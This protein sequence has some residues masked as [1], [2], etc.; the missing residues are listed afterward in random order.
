MNHELMTWAKVK[1]QMLNR[2]SPPGA[3]TSATF[4][5]EVQDL[6]C[7]RRTVLWVGWGSWPESHHCI[8]AMAATRPVVLA[9]WCYNQ[10]LGLWV[11][12]W[13]PGDPFG[14]MSKMQSC[15]EVEN[16]IIQVKNH[17]EVLF[18]CLAQ[19]ST[20]PQELPRGTRREEILP[21]ETGV[22]VAHCASSPS[23][24]LKVSKD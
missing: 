6:S 23:S 2:L 11:L 4:L 21:R 9:Q 19:P 3:P 10:S 13:G 24:L 1:S 5:Q 22:M 16:E 17:S 14:N 15:R 18:T 12:W 7:P 20:P 8:P